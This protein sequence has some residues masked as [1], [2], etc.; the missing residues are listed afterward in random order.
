MLLL[1]I[2]FKVET[3]RTYFYLPKK[4]REK[5]RHTDYEIYYGLLFYRFEVN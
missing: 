5:N 3:D 2:S 4:E 1:Q